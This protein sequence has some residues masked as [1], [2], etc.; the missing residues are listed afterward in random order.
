M[1]DKNRTEQHSLNC[2][3]TP[4]YLSY[5]VRSLLFT[6]FQLSFHYHHLHLWFH[7]G[8]TTNYPGK[9]E[10]RERKRESCQPRWRIAKE[11]ERGGHVWVHISHS[12]ARSTQGVWERY[13]MDGVDRWWGWWVKEGHPIHPSLKH[14]MLQ[15]VQRDKSI[16]PSLSFSLSFLLV[17][18]CPFK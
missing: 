2:V 3:W 10:R 9:K 13:T 5:L 8:T 12:K 15:G 1:K 17:Q 14:F 7:R 6:S 16:H 4:A 18:W 11:R